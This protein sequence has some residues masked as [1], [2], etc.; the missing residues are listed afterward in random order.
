M[1]SCMYVCIILDYM[2]GLV[3]ENPSN[4]TGTGV[5]TFDKAT[6]FLCDLLLL[7]YKNIKR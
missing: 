4:G 3:K 6:P 5:E 2:S 7:F 1:I